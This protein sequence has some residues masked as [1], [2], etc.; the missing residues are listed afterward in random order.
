MKPVTS[1]EGET[2]T[3]RESV[4]IGVRTKVEGGATAPTQQ[5]AQLPQVVCLCLVSCE[6]EDA[7]QDIIAEATSL[8][9][10]NARPDSPPS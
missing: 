9:T 2:I 6:W 7:I 1:G 4:R 8:P 3:A 5:L 10:S